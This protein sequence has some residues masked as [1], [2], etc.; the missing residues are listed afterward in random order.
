MTI[1]YCRIFKDEFEYLPTQEGI[2]NLQTSH[3]VCSGR[4]IYANIV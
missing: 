2:S 1:G 4:P 3:A